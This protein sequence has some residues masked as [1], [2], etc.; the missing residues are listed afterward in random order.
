VPDSYYPTLAEYTP[1]KI[2]LAAYDITVFVCWDPDLV[3]TVLSEPAEY[4]AARELVNFAAVTENDRLEYF[5]RYTSASLGR[6]KNL[7]LDWA[8]LKGPMS[9]ECQQLNRL[10]STC[11]DGNRIKVPRELEDLP[12][13][14]SKAPSFILDTLHEAALKSIKDYRKQS[15]SCD[16]Y[17]FDAIELL[18]CRDDVAMSEFE[19]IQL[20]YR[21]CLKTKSNLADFLH[22]FDFNRL[23]DGEK[24]W[25][26]GQL[27]PAVDTPSLIL[28]GL[29]QSNLIAA[30][31]LRSFRL[32][33][34]GLR[35][36]CV[37][38]SCKDRLGTFLETV[39]RN[40]EL[41]HRKLLV[42]RVSD[43]F[44]MAIYIPQKIEKR[45]ECQVDDSLLLFAFLHS[46][47]NEMYQHRVVPTKANYRLYC[48]GDVFQLYK[49][50][51]EDTWVSIWKGASDDSSYSNIKDTRDKRRQRQKTIGSGVNYDCKMSV[52][53]EKFS[54]PLQRHVG[55]VKRKGII[56]AVS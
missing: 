53:L 25:M 49:K 29:L 23:R 6:V 2:V 52:A 39:S 38:D 36:K 28:N 1:S 9:A 18:L 37:F 55:A 14:D 56:A 13:V 17:S 10:F 4:P 15:H 46:Q 16:G 43:R 44:T 11:V 42:I 40:L 5:A 48:D 20:T 3:P 26:L 24:S 45:R 21:W 19:L 41:F 31:E 22:L 47:G 35:W 54:R 12:R 33:H 34:H 51:R 30:T 32:D 8:R 27:P 50:Q 7:Y